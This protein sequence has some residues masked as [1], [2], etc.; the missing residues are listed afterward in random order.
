MIKMKDITDLRVQEAIEDLKNKIINIEQIDNSAFQEIG[1][2]IIQIKCKTIAAFNKA[3]D[4]IYESDGSVDLFQSLD[5]IKE[6][7][8]QLY[9]KAEGKIADLRNEESFIEKIVEECNQNNS[10]EVH[11]DIEKTNEETIVE[12]GGDT[13][14]DANTE[15]EEINVEEVNVETS[16]FAEEEKEETN[17]LQEQNTEIITD[18]FSPKVVNRLKQWLNLEEDDNEKSDNLWSSQGG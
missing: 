11:E 8:E 4:L 12:T 16:T 1:K 10:T 6:K 3:I 9:Q 5:I 18:G 7:A 15:I 2:D 17:N 14:A 13:I